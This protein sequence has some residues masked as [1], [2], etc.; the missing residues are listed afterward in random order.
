M[1]NAE[2]KNRMSE[3]KR[4]ER[5]EVRAGGGRLQKGAAQTDIDMGTYVRCVQQHEG[6]G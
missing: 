1:S 3:A 2:S 5:K 6:R 4:R